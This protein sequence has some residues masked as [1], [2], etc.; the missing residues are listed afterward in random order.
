[1][2]HI[3]LSLLF[4]K[5]LSLMSAMKA[6]QLHSHKRRQIFTAFDVQ[7]KFFLV[8]IWSINVILKQLSWPPEGNKNKLEEMSWVLRS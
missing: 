2:F 5:F 7:G 3:F 6:V 1:M 8:N 4:E